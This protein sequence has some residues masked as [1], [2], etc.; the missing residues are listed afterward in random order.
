MAKLPPATAS[1]S[2]A[3][4][5]WAAS[6]VVAL[7]GR[8]DGPPLVPPGRAATVARRLAERIAERTADTGFPV[9]L[10]GRLLLSERAAFTGSTRGGT[11]SAGGSCR[12]LPTADGWAAV[13]CAR[14]DDPLLLGAL[15]GAELVGDPWP[16]VTAWLAAHTGAELAERAELLG[17]AAAPVRPYGPPPEPPDLPARPVAGLRV[18][19]FSALWAGPLCAHLLR[20]AGAEV[21]TIETPGRPDGARRGN[22]DF[23]RLLRGGTRSVVLDPGTGPGR[24][25]IAALVDAADIVIEASRPRAL[26]GFGLDAEAAVASGTSWISVT[27]AGRAS[28]RVGFGDDVAAAAGLVAPDA[29]GVPL[30]CGDAIADPLTGLTAAALAMTAPADGSGVLWDI[31]MSDVVARTL[32]APEAD[33]P[34]ARRT[35]RGWVVDTGDGIAPVVAP[36]GR[37][38]TEPAPESG[39]DTAAVLGRLGIVS[40]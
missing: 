16:P 35:A 37:I 20:L 23:H 5:D 10:D 21:I 31:A 9:R 8:P 12:L 40:P 30:F 11:T 36:R 33:P 34:T 39:A 38:A 2:D 4:R 1:G 6:G 29:D 15:I 18:V 27:A 25:A 32:V 28:A 14:P 26:A 17:I 19:D 22:R 3:A 24:A 13:S 7:T